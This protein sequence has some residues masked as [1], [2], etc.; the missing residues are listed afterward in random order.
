MNSGRIGVPLFA[1]ALCLARLSRAEDFESVRPVLNEYCLKC[2]STEK[3]KGD[4]DLE[5]F[6]SLLSVKKHPKI[7]Q[8]VL[9]QLSDNE[10]PPAKEKV[11]PTAEQK[12]QLMAW[13]GGTL[14]AVALERAGDPG[15]VVLRRLSNAEYTYTI[16]D[17]TG[18]ESL[19]PAREFPVDGAA[20]EGF[21]NTGN[22]LVMSPSLITKYL[23]AG[24]DIA[25]HAVLLPDGIRFSAKTSRRD[26]TEEI[27][28]EIRALYNGF[29]DPRGGDKVNLQGIVF[30]TNAGGRLAVEKYLAATLELRGGGKTIEAVAG[31][32]G[33]S[34]KYLETLMTAL[35]SKE[36][37]LL[38]D[39][40]R[41][42]WQ[43]AKASDVGA[44][45]AEVAQWQKLLWKFN[46]VGHIGKLNGPEVVARA[47][48]AADEQAGR[49]AERFRLRRMGKKSR[50]ISWRA[51]RAMGMK[52]ISWSGNNR[53]WL[54][55]AGR[56]CCFATFRT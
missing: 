24:K 7:W 47:R 1:L 21:T 54:R 12:Q 40:L 56:I 33:L 22:A 30:E 26:R 19:D 3:Q 41:A 13:V 5:Q 10:M 15:P 8:K 55:P 35:R 25:S 39:G 18:V 9:E 49:E 16:R 32:R 34:A 17:L 52:G 51:M 27:L 29:T 48:H 11:Q 6:S 45:T 44:L 42:R 38:L 37:S 50:C 23:D 36:P 43:S 4:L 53:N 20:G 46:S 28:A 31:T 14:D 2:H